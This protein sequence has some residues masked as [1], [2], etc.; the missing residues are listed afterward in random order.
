MAEI[1][2][3]DALGFDEADLDANRNGYMSKAQRFKLRRKQQERLANLKNG[4]IVVTA[5]SVLAFAMVVIFRL[6]FGFCAFSIGL[7]DVMLGILGT[8]NLRRWR[9]LDTDL[10]KGDVS[11]A[12]GRISLDV[13]PEG[14]VQVKYLL[15]VQRLR[16]DISKDALL[17]FRNQ[18]DYQVYYLPN[19]ETVL[20]A[21]PMEM[22]EK[23]KR[24]G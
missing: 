7:V 4:A 24:P 18:E 17:A 19:S 1:S 2:L 15:R 13:Q 5:G 21:E 16:F 23:P 22:E 3:M 10:Y 11:V 14:E 9:R 12:S 6:N 8:V 20:S